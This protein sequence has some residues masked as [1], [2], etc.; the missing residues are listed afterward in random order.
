MASLRSPALLLIGRAGDL[1][2]SRPEAVQL[3]GDSREGI[4]QRDRAAY[5]A[6][7]HRREE[8]VR[9]AGQHV[10]GGAF[11]SEEGFDSRACAV[12]HADDVG[13]LGQARHQSRGHGDAAEAGSVVD[14]QGDRRVIGGGGEIAEQHLVGHLLAE[15]RRRQQQ[16]EV[17]ADLGG[18]S[19]EAL[20][21]ALRLIGGAGD[22]HLVAGPAGHDGPQHRQLLILG[23][24]LVLPVRAERQI[25]EDA[26]PCVGLHVLLEG[27]EVDVLVFSEGGSDRRKDPGE[28][29]HL[30][31]PVSSI[32]AMRSTP[33]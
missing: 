8:E 13:V 29:L 27:G 16:A 3:L 15:V 10:E 6:G 12:L 14:E 4:G 28:S 19:E 30:T 33:E 11:E 17:G 7:H 25:A 31:P 18:G 23:E 1:I 2:A 20:R 32:P 22:H 21:V 5:G 26:R 9:R 24:A